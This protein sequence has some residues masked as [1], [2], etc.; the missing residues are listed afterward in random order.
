MPGVAPPAPA[1][2]ADIDRMQGEIAQTPRFVTGNTLTVDSLLAGFPANASRRGMYARV[3]DYGGYVD[4]VLRCDYFADL[5]YHQWVPVLAEYGR[6][7]PLVGDL[8]LFP[9]KSPTSVVLTG[10]LPLGVTRNITLSTLNG[11]PGEIKE[12]KA[13]LTSLLGSLNIAGSGLGSAVSLALGGYQRY[14]LD[15]SSGTLTWVRMM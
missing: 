5:D 7:M 3:S 15:S 10:T 13:G 8:T 2:R 12:I 6:A 9:L 4:R 11:R 14:V 1:T